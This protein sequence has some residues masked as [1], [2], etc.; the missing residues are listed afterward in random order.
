MYW[1]PQVSVW[2]AFGFTGWGIGNYVTGGGDYAFWFLLA[3]VFILHSIWLTIDH[4][5]EKHEN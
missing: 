2:F 5:G 3:M 4:Q 1:F